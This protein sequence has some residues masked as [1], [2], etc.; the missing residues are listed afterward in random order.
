VNA[1]P[2]MGR[3]MTTAIPNSKGFFY[4]AEGHLSLISK[5]IEEILNVLVA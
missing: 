2:A 4:P 3:Y 1:P 5:Y